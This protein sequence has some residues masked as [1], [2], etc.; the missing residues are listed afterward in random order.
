MKDYFDIWMLSRSFSFEA[1]ILSEAIKQTFS[2]RQTALPVSEPVGLSE[3]FGT[4]ESKQRQW[5]GFIRKQRRQETSP[6]LPDVVKL[7]RTFLMPVITDTAIGSWNAEDGW[8]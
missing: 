8:S 1:N 5:S 3:E 2:K 4:E 7:V 6:E